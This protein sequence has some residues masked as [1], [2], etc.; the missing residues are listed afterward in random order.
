MCVVMYYV[1]VIIG[2]LRPGTYRDN[3]KFSMLLY[4]HVRNIYK[5]FK[6]CTGKYTL[7]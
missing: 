3:N 2:K 4:I 5:A 6:T 1:Y 7:I